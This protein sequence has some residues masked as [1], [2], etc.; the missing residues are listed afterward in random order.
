VDYFTLQDDHIIELTSIE[1][2]NGVAKV[3]LFAVDGKDTAG[4]WFYVKV[5]AQKDAPVAVDDKYNV[6]Q[7]SLNKVA[8]NKGVLANDKNPDGKT[9]FKAYLKTDATNGTVKM[10]STGA[11]TYE[12]GSE[13]GEDTF[14]YFIVNAEGDTSEVATVTLTVQYKNQ[15]PKFIADADTIGK[16]LAAL[17]EDFSTA[18]KFTK[19]EIQSWFED[20]SDA[21]TK[22]TFTTRSDDSLLSPSMSSGN[23][24]VKSVKNAC[25]DANVILV[26]TDTKKASTELV[27]PA[28]IACVNDKPEL[29]KKSDTVYVGTKPVWKDTFDLASLF[30]DVDGDTLK[31]E[32]TAEQKSDDYIKWTV[33]GSKLIVSSKDSASLAAGSIVFVNVKASD[34]E[35][36][37]STK[38]GIFAEKAPTTGIAPVIAMPKATWQNAIR[39][40][41][42]AVALI[43]MQGRVMWKA[44]LPVSEADVRN[45]ATQVQGRKILRVNKQTWTIK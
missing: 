27:I 28:S 39:A 38:I 11:F 9:T 12:A 44:K 29:L 20:D 33:K 31:Y 4:V 23:L 5:E 37:I 24:L 6:Y 25:G 45:A 15:A 42:G 32:V 34:A 41:R 40:N 19:A 35:T 2:A 36:A 16:R 7:D 21:V 8:A 18:V 1:N 17:K 22:L 10:D 30:K 14:T 26:A 13:L 43:D 3:N